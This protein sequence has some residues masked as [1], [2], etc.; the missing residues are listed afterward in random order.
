M[1]VINI[2][3]LTKRKRIPHRQHYDSTIFK[4]WDLQVTFPAS[5]KVRTYVTACIH[6]CATCQVH[7]RYELIKHAM[8]V[9]IV[10]EQ[11]R[12][13]QP[14]VHTLACSEY[15]PI[16]VVRALFHTQVFFIRAIP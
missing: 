8:S 14:L 1:H 9:Y 11:L 13:H 2:L 16:R 7:S 12:H 4:K 5:Y 3:L 15:F 6:T 10:R